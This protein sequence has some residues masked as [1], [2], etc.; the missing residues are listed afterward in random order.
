MM[1]DLKAVC[2]I[3]PEEVGVTELVYY[4]VLAQ[5]LE[6]K[7]G[8]PTVIYTPE[9]T[10]NRQNM[11]QDTGHGRNGRQDQKEQRQKQDD[12]FAQQLRLGLT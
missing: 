1:V 3:D 5:I 8:T 12:S 6:E 10:E 7:T 2:G 11:D 4:P 9:Q